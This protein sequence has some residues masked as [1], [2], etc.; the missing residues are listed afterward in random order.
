VL[1]LQARNGSKVFGVSGAGLR[2]YHL[3]GAARAEGAFMGVSGG[4]DLGACSFW[5]P[6]PLFPRREDFIPALNGFN[7][8]NALLNED[9]YQELRRL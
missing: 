6:E 8:R 7:F 4:S 9:F 5:Y 1:A 3:S 2:G